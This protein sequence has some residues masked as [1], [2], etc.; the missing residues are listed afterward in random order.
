MALSSMLETYYRDHQNPVNKAFHM[1]GIPIILASIPLV[2]FSPAVGIS[3][4]VFGWI[5]QF[6]GHA[7]EG[8]PP[9]FFRDP[10]F[11]LVGCRNSPS[12][13]CAVPATAAARAPRFPTVARSSRPR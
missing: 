6:I 7:F 13:P 4:F 12:R 10:R 8:K 2:F 9:T 1:V 3:L 11:L 5:L